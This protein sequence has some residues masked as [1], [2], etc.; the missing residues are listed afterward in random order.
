MRHEVRITAEIPHHGRF[1]C[2]AYTLDMMIRRHLPASPEELRRVL[3]E[4]I[5]EIDGNPEPYADVFDV[6]AMLLFLGDVSSYE[7]GDEGA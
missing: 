5:G 1:S 3:H 2:S 4:R 6:S 7:F